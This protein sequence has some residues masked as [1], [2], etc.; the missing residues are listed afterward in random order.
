[1]K[2]VFYINLDERTKRKESCEKQLQQLEWKFER[3]S[4]I[5]HKN[6]AIGC[7]LSHLRILQR[8]KKEKLKYVIIF[9][10]DFIIVDIEKFKGAFQ[11]FLKQKP[12]F[13]VLKLGANPFP[14][15]KE[16]TKTYLNVN[17]SQTTHAYMVF[18]HYYDTLI[19]NYK[20]SIYLMYKYGKGPMGIFCCDAWQNTLI[21]NNNHTWLVL[22]PLTITQKTD[23]SDI[24]NKIVDY[25][26]YCL[27]IK[28]GNNIIKGIR[29]ISV[30]TEKEVFE[31]LAKKKLYILLNNYK[32]L[33]NEIDMI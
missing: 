12:Y 28:T 21:H 9:E 29:G 24:E 13:D 1:M 25:V 16:I 15:Y 2:N 19:K 32:R 18:D 5:K 27:N 6:G 33:K 31:K 3:F 4:A 14:P 8:A 23:Y 26:N 10:D 22:L 20:E 17:F 7:A 11:N 30:G